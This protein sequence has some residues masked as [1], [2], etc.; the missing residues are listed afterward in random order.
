VAGAVERIAR[1]LAGARRATW[2]R[3]PGRVN[4][5][6]DHTD[7]NEGFVLPMAIDRDC[8]VAA[9]PADGIRVASLDLGES[10]ELAAD[11]ST[12]VETLASDWGRIVAAVVHVLAG[13]GRPGAGMDALIA[14]DVPIGSGLSSSAAF[15]VAIA[16]AL[17]GIAGWEVEPTDLAKVCREAEE[18][19]TGV[20]CGI[21]DQLV[22]VAGRE[23]AAILLDCRSLDTRPV[24][25][26]DR[27]GLLVVH[28]GQ[29]RALADSAYADRRRAC[30][31]LA[32]RL[33]VTSLRNAL[34]AQV[35][36]DPLGRHVVSESAR[37][38]EAAT[39][40]EGGDLVRFG[41]LLNASHASLRDDF[42]VSTPE[43]DAL[44]DALV[45]AGALGARLTG[46]GFGGS[47][48]AVCEVGSLPAVA[49]AATERYRTLTN[50]EPRAF[51]CHAVD[52]AG[53]LDVP[54]S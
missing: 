35:E 21:M 33:G 38:L 6:G 25:I 32:A 51:A 19:A 44:V 10:V 37:V 14:S 2:F 13:M 28:S 3:A 50:L 36:D 9:H 48:I 27:A 52:G 45:D 8:V 26:P 12:G 5:I 24:R 30:E 15:E 18:R 46:A 23:G 43:L 34:L 22:S 17:A 31:K 53:R 7:Y 39:A 20:P 54:P 11:G 4:L 16:T 42:A 47:V 49:D 41:E 1:S 29:E 40:L